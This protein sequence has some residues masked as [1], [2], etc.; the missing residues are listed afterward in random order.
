[1]FVY[2]FSLL[3]VYYTVSIETG[4]SPSAGTTGSPWL[5]VTGEFNRGKIFNVNV[6]S[7]GIQPNRSDM[8]VFRRLTYLLLNMISLLILFLNGLSVI[9]GNCDIFHLQQTQ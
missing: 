4:S 7:D 6:P 1:M 8:V 3:V 9:L 5:R 2:R